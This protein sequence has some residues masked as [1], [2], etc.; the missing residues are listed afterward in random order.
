MRPGDFN[1]AVVGNLWPVKGH[2][3]LVEAAALLVR[4]VPTVRFFC[5]GE[6]VM[7]P[8]LEMRLRELGIQDRVILLGH[9]KDIPAILAR[10]DALALCSSAEGLSNAI[11]EAMA[12]R[13]PVVATRVGGNP[14]LLDG[15]RGLLVPYGD[16]RALADAVARIF[17]NRNEARAMGRK[18]RAFVEAELSLD[19]MRMAHEELYRRAL[20]LPAPTMAE[21]LDRLAAHG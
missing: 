3:T 9:R 10:A 14:E 19:R 4:R 1:I 11:M 21:P 16:A 20:D 8:A 17:T 13:L 7:R 5:A 18:G 12:A 6:G 15:E 2:T